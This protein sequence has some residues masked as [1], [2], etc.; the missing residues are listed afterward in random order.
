MPILK[1]EKIDEFEN[2]TILVLSQVSMRSKMVEGR[3]HVAVSE[4]DKSDSETALE[5]DNRT[6]LAKSDKVDN[7][8]LLIDIPDREA[9]EH[10][11]E[12]VNGL[13]EQF[14]QEERKEYPTISEYLVLEHG[15][16][17]M[18]GVKAVGDGNLLDTNPFTCHKQV[19]KAHVLLYSE[20]LKYFYLQQEKKVVL[21]PKVIE[22]QEDAR[23]LVESITDPMQKRQNV[24]IT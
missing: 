16:T 8:D 1:G 15:F 11:I 19:H 24:I 17:P 22:T 3:I 2:V 9:L 10:L 4:R 20:R 18:I 7:I 5:L 21:I 6:S 13:K 12:F 14:Y 23:K